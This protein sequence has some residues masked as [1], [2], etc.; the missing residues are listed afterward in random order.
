MER[1]SGKYSHAFLFCQSAIIVFIIVALGPQN[2][3]Y[4]NP[5]TP[6]PQATPASSVSNPG[7]ANKP[8]S[9][10]NSTGAPHKSSAVA[11]H[12]AHVQGIYMLDPSERFC[13]N[14]PK[15]PFYQRVSD[16]AVCCRGRQL[17]VV[18]VVPETTGECALSTK[19]DVDGMLDSTNLVS[20]LSMICFSG[21][22]KIM[23][24]CW[25]TNIS[26]IFL[27]PDNW[28]M[29]RLCHLKYY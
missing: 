27:T 7:T 11:G 14:I 21:Q 24:I 12:G 29:S 5:N 22:I 18:S 10:L 15:R 1:L 25:R 17:P 4:C 3:V 16:G 23:Y 26:T 6:A 2:F 13:R 28:A 20:R 9:T 19:T 8:S